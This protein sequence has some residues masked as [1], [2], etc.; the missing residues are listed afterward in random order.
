M[1]QIGFLL[2]ATAMMAIINLQTAVYWG[3]LS[4]CKPLYKSQNHYSCSDPA[5]YGAVA[6]FAS[7]LF[8]AQVGYTMALARWRG[9]LIDETGAYDEVNITAAGEESERV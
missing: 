2:G 8:T 5:G 9:D 7:I 4:R 1:L 6:A 3:Q